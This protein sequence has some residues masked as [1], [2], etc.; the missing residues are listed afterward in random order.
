MEVLPATFRSIETM[1]EDNWPFTAMV[2][3]A[4]P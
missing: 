2:T 3:A 1:L 4:K